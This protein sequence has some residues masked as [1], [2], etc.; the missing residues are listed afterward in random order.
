MSQPP[1]ASGDRARS[2]PA[3]SPVNP[4]AA[5]V[6][7]VRAPRDGSKA[8]RLPTSDPDV[9]VWAAGPVRLDRNPAVHARLETPTAAP[10]IANRL[11]P[12]PALDERGASN[13][14]DDALD[15]TRLDEIGRLA[16]LASSYWRSVELA[17]DRGDT[18]TVVVHC[19]QLAAVVR[20]AFAI[21]KTLGETE[22][23]T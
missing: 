20:E 15:F 12:N 1:P 23:A 17:V 13:R 5:R 3:P 21:V 4:I 9:G 10:P 14:I 18:L 6:Q 19:E 7:D 11:M 16:A 22:A 2:R 8:C